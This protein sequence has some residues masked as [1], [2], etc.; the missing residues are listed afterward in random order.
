MRVCDGKGVYSM[1]DAY[2]KGI[3]SDALLEAAYN[4]YTAKQ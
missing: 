2:D 4:A 3:L 1:K